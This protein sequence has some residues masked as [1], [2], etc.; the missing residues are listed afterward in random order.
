M[1]FLWVGEGRFSLSGRGVRVRSGFGVG[2]VW[3]RLLR[4]Q[5]VDYRCT[6]ALEPSRGLGIGWGGVLFGVDLMMD[7]G[8][9]C[10]K[11]KDVENV[12][13]IYIC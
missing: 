8:G 12:C 7:F 5:W 6:I 3:V 13:V 1:C 2:S 11:G 9:C 4:E 10:L